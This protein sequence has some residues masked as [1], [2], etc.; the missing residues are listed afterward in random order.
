MSKIINNI[1]DIIS[2][3]DC[4]YIFYKNKEVFEELDFQKL[5]IDELI[6]VQK[7]INKKLKI[8]GTL[9]TDIIEKIKIYKYD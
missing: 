1:D 5:N 6:E 4:F 9:N 8:K 2:A 7:F 3:Y